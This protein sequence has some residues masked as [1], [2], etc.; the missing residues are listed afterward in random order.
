MFDDFGW[1]DGFYSFAMVAFGYYLKKALDWL[2]AKAKG[3]D[4][5]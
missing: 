2:K 3:L 5:Q 4:P 1:L